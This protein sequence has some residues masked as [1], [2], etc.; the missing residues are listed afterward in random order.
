MRCPACNQQKKLQEVKPG[1]WVFRCPRCQAIFSEHLY[2]GE[3]YEYVLP[4]WAKEEVA[5]EKLRYY[6]FMCLGEKGIIRRHGWYGP[7]TKLIHQTG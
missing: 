4:Y 7:E 3:S 5:P 1:S 2:L 6:D